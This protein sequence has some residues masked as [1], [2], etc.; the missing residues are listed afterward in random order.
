MRLDQITGPYNTNIQN[1]SPAL[2][3]TRTMLRTVQKGPAIKEQQD[4]HH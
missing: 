2:Q 4:L 1:T 3:T